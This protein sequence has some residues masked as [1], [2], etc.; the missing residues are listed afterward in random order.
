MTH[1]AMNQMGHEAPNLI[2]ANTAGVTGKIGR[3]LPGYMTM[4]E[5][6]MGAMMMMKRPR[7]SISMLGGKGPFDEIDMGGMFTIVKVR[8]HL[9]AANAAGWYEHPAGSVADVASD[10]D[11]AR[12]N[13]K[14]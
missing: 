9:T 5:S 3:L 14:L 11:L 8:N 7:N 12:D 4:G 2:G 13:I 10:A 6:G 1:H